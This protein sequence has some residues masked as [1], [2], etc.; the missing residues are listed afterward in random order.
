MTLHKQY[1]QQRNWKPVRQSLSNVLEKA[2]STRKE[3]SAE[4]FCNKVTSMEAKEDS[5]ISQVFKGWDVER[6]YIAP[7]YRPSSM[8]ATQ[9]V[10]AK[11]E[12]TL[13][14]FG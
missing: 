1:Q 5:E 2:H 6:L 7:R 9:T 8:R 12:L 11:T 3:S 4:P 10:Q 14:K 13:A